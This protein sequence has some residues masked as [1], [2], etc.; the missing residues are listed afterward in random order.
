MWYEPSLEFLRALKGALLGRAPTRSLVSL[1]RNQPENV[2]HRR[3]TGRQP[4]ER[5]RLD[6]LTSTDSSG[7]ILQVSSEVGLHMTF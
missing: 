3:H 4:E 2:R 5:A 6:N 7:P 1:T